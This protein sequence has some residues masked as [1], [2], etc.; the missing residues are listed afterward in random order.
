MQGKVLSVLLPAG[1]LRVVTL[2]AVLAFEAI[3]ALYMLL[4][5]LMG[6]LSDK[7]FN[8]VLKM[9]GI[10]KVISLP[11]PS[12]S[13]RRASARP[14]SIRSVTLRPLSGTAHPCQSPCCCLDPCTLLSH[15]HAL[16]CAVLQV[17]PLSE[18]ERARLKKAETA[19][20]QPTN[21]PP[22]GFQQRMINLGTRLGLWLVNSAGMSHERWPFGGLTPAVPFC[23]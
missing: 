3:I 16:S 21:R 13:A 1:F 12:C 5:T 20:I 23:T 22:R 7:V 4:T 10:D 8:D 19:F 15:P 2:Q 14:R 18:E 6:G 9:Q 11:S 17:K